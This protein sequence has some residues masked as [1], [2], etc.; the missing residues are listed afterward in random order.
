[1]PSIPTVL[2][3]IHAQTLNSHLFYSGLYLVIVE[4]SSDCPFWSNFFPSELNG[5]KRKLKPVGGRLEVQKYIHEMRDDRAKFVVAIDS[6]YRLLLNRLYN[7]PRI[8]ETKC[9]SIENLM[10]FTLNITSIIRNLSHDIEY[11]SH[12]INSWLEEFDSVTY[13]LMIADFLIEKNNIGQPCVKEYCFPFLTRNDTPKFDSRKITDFIKTLN[14]D[15]Q[16]FDELAELLKD[17]KPRSH[18]R[19][20][21]FFSA[22]L[23]FVTHEFKRICNKKSINIANDVFYA[24]SIASLQSC[25][26]TDP[27][28]QDIQEKALLAVNDVTALLSQGN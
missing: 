4:G 8:V 7:H 6:D 13:P 2:R 14:L 5:Y 9:H 11:E 12:G 1:M 10:L 17:F 16:E 24:M 15:I 19:G 22:V 3:V 21:F 25:I 28:L 26:S 27:I 18:I 23:C 20:H